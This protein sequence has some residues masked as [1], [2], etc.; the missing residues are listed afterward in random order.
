MRKLNQNQVEKIKKGYPTL[1]GLI[2]KYVQKI[3]NENTDL[4]DDIMLALDII[5]EKQ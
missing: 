5:K 4:Q 1:G 2:V 3:G